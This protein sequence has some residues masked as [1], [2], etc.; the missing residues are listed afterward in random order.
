MKTSK[1]TTVYS[2][3]NCKKE[4]ESTDNLVRCAIC[5]AELCWDCAVAITISSNTDGIKRVV[6]KYFCPSVEQ[7]NIKRQSPEKP[8]QRWPAR[9][10]PKNPHH[11]CNIFNH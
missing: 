5:D 8:Q 1:M 3:D 11:I 9:G 10:D 2:C 7:I 4:V 6:T